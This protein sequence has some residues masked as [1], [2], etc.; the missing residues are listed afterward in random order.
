MTKL[1]II[2]IFWIV[3]AA[4][5]LRPSSRLRTL[6]LASFFGL[7]I[8]CGLSHQSIWPFFAWDMWCRLVPPAVECFEIS[9]VDAD[10]REWRYDFSAVPP[11]CPAIIEQKC[12]AIL[13]GQPDKAPCV[14]EWLLRRAHELRDSP[15]GIEPRWWCTDLGLLPVGPASRE[16]CSGWA[17]EPSSRPAEFVALVV[18][19][20]RARF[21]TRSDDAGFDVIAETRFPWTG[22]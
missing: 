10:S 8:P 4:A 22:S 13:L 7:L 1:F 2:S 20:K 14:A 18:R 12:G 19:K 21:S 9:L 3:V 11:A 15:A 17:S 5:T 6:F 16:S